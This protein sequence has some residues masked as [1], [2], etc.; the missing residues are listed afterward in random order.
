MNKFIYIAFLLMSLAITTSYSLRSEP[1]ISINSE[2]IDKENLRAFLMVLNIIK[3][4]YVEPVDEKALLEASLHGML[5]SLDPYSEYFTDE[6]YK[7]MLERVNAEFG[8]VGIE[9]A[10]EGGG[11]K[12]I[13]PI[14]DTPAYKIGILPG[15][16]I[17]EIN[18]KPL[19]EMSRFDSVK[20]MRG[21]P[22]SKVQLTVVRAGQDKPL[23]FNITRE[24]IRFNTVKYASF[25]NIAYIRVLSFSKNTTQNFLESYNRII[26]DNPNIGGLIIDLRSNPGGLVDQAIEMASLFV[27]DGNILTIKERERE[28]AFPTKSNGNILTGDLPVIVL[29]DKGSASSSE[30][31]AGALQD[32]KIAKVI[33]AKSFGKGTVQVTINRDLPKDYGGFKFT[34]AY[35]FTPKGNKINGVGIAPDILME[36]KDPQKLLNEMHKV[37]IDTTDHKNNSSKKIPDN[38]WRIMLKYDNVLAKAL[39]SIEHKSNTE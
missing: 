31:V 13:A 39:E 5:E 2:L 26:K 20:K 7:Q 30:I 27:T 18:N 10:F 16:F 25:N 24:M 22:G 32:Y 29:I 14:E 21:K 11:M 15:D 37:K 1:E 19:S 34:A 38:L 4:K 28:E 23:S 9:F 35:F 6:E 8:G 17:V 36:Q 3:N 33:G 12:V